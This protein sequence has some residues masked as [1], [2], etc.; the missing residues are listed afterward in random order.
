MSGYASKREAMEVLKHTIETGWNSKAPSQDP[1]DYYMER[2][3][4]ETFQSRGHGYGWGQIVT[5]ET[6]QHFERI[7]ARHLRPKARERLLAE[8]KADQARFYDMSKCVAEIP[9]GFT[10]RDMTDLYEAARDW[11]ALM[12]EDA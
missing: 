2:V 12:K 10:A 4:N 9:E 7:L 11:V 6:T 3:F 1:S 8:A 5:D